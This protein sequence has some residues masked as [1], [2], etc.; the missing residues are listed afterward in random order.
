MVSIYCNDIFL[1]GKSKY[2]NPLFGLMF[3]KKLKKRESVILDVS[4][5][6]STVIHMAFVFQNLDIICLN[7]EMKVI[8]V[9]NN[10]KPFSKVI[11]PKKRSYYYIESAPDS[12]N[13]KIGD[14]LKFIEKKGI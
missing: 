5:Y 3:A 6:P 8:D 9:R 7:K 12:F 2:I 10:V 1:T 13:V 11:N 4:N 14:K